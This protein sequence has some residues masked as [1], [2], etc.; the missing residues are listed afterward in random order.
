MTKRTTLTIIIAVLF[1]VAA[2]AAWKFMPRTL[3]D[4]ECSDVYRHFADMELQ[5]VSVTYVRDKQVNDSTRLPV[6][7]LQAGSDRGWQLL[8]SLFGYTEANRKFL[9]DTTIS[10]Q[11]KQTFINNPSVQYFMAHRETPN[12]KIA[13]GTIRPD[14]LMVYIVPLLRCVTIFETET[15]Q[16][17]RNAVFSSIIEIR[18]EGIDRNKGAVIDYIL[19]DCNS[20][21]NTKQQIP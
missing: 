16:Q 15:M 5:D 20:S 2:V 13:P 18:E 1:I 3:K 21:N 14:D 7:L 4:E 9:D 11:V 10:D 17:T 12:R 8:D 19:N 6:T